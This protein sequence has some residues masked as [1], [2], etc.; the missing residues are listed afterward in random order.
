MIAFL[1]LVAIVSTLGVIV[2]TVKNAFLQRN[3]THAQSEKETSRTRAKWLEHD[4]QK[5]Y[6]IT[7]MIR[8]QR[9][10]FRK[11]L[12]TSVLKNEALERKLSAG[13][14]D[15]FTRERRLKR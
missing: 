15:K 6:A 14:S 10:R 2:L 8:D 13:R 12:A 1:A 9:D 11:S 3:L 7:N 5:A 4:L